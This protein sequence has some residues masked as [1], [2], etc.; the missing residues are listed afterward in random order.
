MPRSR[1]GFSLMRPSIQWG[2]HEPSGPGNAIGA[3]QGV[4]MLQNPVVSVGRR[5]R[6]A[7]RSGDRTRNT[8]NH[9]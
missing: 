5:R 9:S 4:L 8:S 7:V 6:I 3:G 2:P 1:T